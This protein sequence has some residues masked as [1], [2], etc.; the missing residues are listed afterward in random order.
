MSQS[1]NDDGE[2]DEEREI[3]REWVEDWLTFEDRG[4][5][6]LDEIQDLYLDDQFDTARAKIR[7]FLDARPDAF[8]AIHYSLIGVEEYWED[9]HDQMG[10]EAVEHL[11][12]ISEEYDHLSLEFQIAKAEHEGP[13][14][15]IITGGEIHSINY[16]TYD[17]EIYIRH[18]LRSGKKDLLLTNDSISNILYNGSIYIDAGVTALQRASD[19]GLK[20]TQSELEILG[21]RLEDME[22]TITDISESLEKIPVIEDNDHESE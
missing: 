15:N 16:D 17:N 22:S 14:E 11:S 4:I 1:S 5:G 20:L 6:I 13:R 9:V 7:N 12:D 8:R 10:A 21:D 18:S 19:Q 2:A 3:P